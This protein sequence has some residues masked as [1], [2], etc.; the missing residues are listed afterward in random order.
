MMIKL[1]GL[2]LAF[3]AYNDEHDHRKWQRTQGEPK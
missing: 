3:V 1:L 2:V